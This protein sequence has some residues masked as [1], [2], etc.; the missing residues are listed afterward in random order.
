[1]AGPVW[2]MYGPLA[3]GIPL[4]ADVANQAITLLRTTAMVYLRDFPTAQHKKWVAA[5]LRKTNAAAP[6]DMFMKMACRYRNPADVKTMDI[7]V[8]F[9]RMRKQFRPLRATTESGFEAWE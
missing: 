3:G 8:L 7:V 4:T 5:L 1:M 9:Q 2:T 6:K